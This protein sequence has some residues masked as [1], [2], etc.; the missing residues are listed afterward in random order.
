MR[1]DAEAAAARDGRAAANHQGA[2]VNEARVKGMMMRVD[3]GGVG[4]RARWVYESERN[5]S[6]TLVRQ[7]KRPKRRPRGGHIGAG[8]AFVESRA[9]IRETTV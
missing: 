5:V 1:D 3:E 2:E 8:C 7:Q 4:A 6:E 9:L